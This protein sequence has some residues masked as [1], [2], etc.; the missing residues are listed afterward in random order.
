MPGREGGF[1]TWLF[2]APNSRRI[3]STFFVIE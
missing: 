2:I 3:A 1:L